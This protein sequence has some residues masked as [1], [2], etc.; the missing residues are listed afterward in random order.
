MW[1]WWSTAEV[2][3]ISAD[4]FESLKWPDLIALVF[5]RASKEMVSFDASTLLAHL[6]DPITSV[7]T[8]PSFTFRNSTASIYVG[9]S[10]PTGICNAWPALVLLP[11]AV[12]SF[13]CC[14]LPRTQSPSPI[15]LFTLSC[16]LILIVTS[17][18]RRS[19][20]LSSCVPLDVSMFPD[21]RLRASFPLRL[22]S[23]L[24]ALLFR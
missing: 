24:E 4:V 23:L 5:N 21:R 6:V 8:S 20:D 13:S 15:S 17:G 2:S 16:R 22:D 11:V 18:P 10:D 14:L 7:E 1:L 19:I 3:I 12:S 9:A